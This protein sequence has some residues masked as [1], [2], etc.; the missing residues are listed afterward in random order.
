MAS[1]NMCFMPKCQIF[2]ILAKPNLFLYL[3]VNDDY[4]YMNER[5]LAMA[6]KIA[7]QN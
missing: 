4:L 7:A 2:V 1:G 6:K 5:W 3:N